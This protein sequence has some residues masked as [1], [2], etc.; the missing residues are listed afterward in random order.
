MVG[1]ATWLVLYL[2]CAALM[3]L[4]IGTVG[5]HLG[6]DAPLPGRPMSATTYGK[7]QV[8]SVCV[9]SVSGSREE[10]EAMLGRLNAVLHTLSLPSNGPFSLPANVDVGCPRGPA[11]YDAGS[12]ALRV[13]EEAVDPRPRPSPYQLHVFVMPSVTLQMLPVAPEL[14]D[15]QPTTEEYILDYQDQREVIVPV[16]LGLYTTPDELAHPATLEAF[17]DRSFGLRPAAQAWAPPRT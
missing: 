3:M 7:F 8:L 9:E 10:S 14:I 6:D 5:R 2:A 1:R 12:T 4:T 15:R 17:L 11:H 16:T 13:A